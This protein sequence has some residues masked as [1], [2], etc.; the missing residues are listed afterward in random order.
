MD[1]KSPLDTQE[2]VLPFLSACASLAPTFL[3]LGNH[4]WM[5]DNTDLAAIS[6]TGVAILDNCWV[7]RVVDG[8]EVVI[9]G[10]ISGY[11]MDYRR[12]LA[13]LDEQERTEVRYPKEH[14]ISGIGG[15]VTASQH[16]P[17][18]AWLQAF[19]ATAPNLPHILLSHHPEYLPLVPPSVDLVLSGHAHGG[20]W[21]VFSHGVWCP[22]QGLWPK[23][24]KGVYEGRLVVS[25]GLANTAKVPR[26]FN[27]TETVFI[28]SL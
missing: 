10:L 24:T 28:E 22:G 20:Q 18:T 3:S 5:L 4:E 27:P 6:S 7:E 2:L 25:A 19:S 13:T 8:R 26:I 11:V 17:D 14:T 15:T 23:Y 16:H 9:G 1:D 21:R 12:F